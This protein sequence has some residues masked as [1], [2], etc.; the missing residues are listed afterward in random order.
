MNYFKKNYS[1]YIEE[2]ATGV[3]TVTSATTA[4][5]T[6]LNPITNGLYLTVTGASG[7]KLF[8]SITTYTLTA[9]GTGYFTGINITLSG[10]DGTGAVAPTATVVG[11]VIT[12]LTQ[13]AGIGTGTGYTTALSV[14][15]TNAATN[16]YYATAP[17]VALDQE[18][19]IRQSLLII[20]L[21]L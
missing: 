19:Y 6:I 18:R 20:E 9:G 1:G 8:R 15:V 2:V 10:G 17:T 14:T 3:I 12:V 7:L 11:G 5:V 4:N 16:G 13:P 21:L